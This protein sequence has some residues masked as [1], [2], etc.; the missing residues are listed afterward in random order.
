MGA[1][2]GTAGHL[3]GDVTTAT[4][5]VA[6][7]LCGIAGILPDADSDTGQTGR[8]IM[9]FAAAV[10]PL[11]LSDSLRHRGLSNDALI[12]AG[13]ASY[14][15]IRFGMGAILRR[16]TVHRGMWHSVPAALIAGLLVWFLCAR[17]PTNLRAFKSA[18]VVLGYLTHLAL[19]ELYSVQ[20]YRG[21]I[22]LKKSF[23]T[24][25]KIWGP[26]FRAN[27][28]TFTHLATLV[29]F[30][31]KNPFSGPLPVNDLLSPHSYEVEWQPADSP[32]TTPESQPYF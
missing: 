25:L 20:L 19:D 15:I 23:G 26:D 31:F 3:Y 17:D 13:G 1:A 29:F 30:L 9:G 16:Y 27:L 28:A 5:A 8:E 24:A 6:G 14:I 22:R 12:L 11:L 7:G 21:R 32:E 4:A 2:Y 10:T 18:A